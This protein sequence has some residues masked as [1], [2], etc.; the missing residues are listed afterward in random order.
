[1]AFMPKSGPAAELARIVKE[2]EKESGA[3]NGAGVELLNARH[4][5]DQL[6]AAGATDEE[7][8][9]A[10]RRIVLADRKAQRSEVRRKVLEDQYKAATHALRLQNEQSARVAALQAGLAHAE[11]ARK[12]SA[13]AAT[14]IQLKFAAANAQYLQTPGEL[15]DCPIH[16]VDLSNSGGA[17]ARVDP[18]HASLERFAFTITNLA[19]KELP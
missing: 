10:D 2:V 7:L 19:R 13:T 3:R 4:D 12:A 6:Y 18:L 11:A 15:P 17:N 5:R 16:V 14:Y 8:D 9:A 1:M